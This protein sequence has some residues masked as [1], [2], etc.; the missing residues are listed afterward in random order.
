MFQIY[1]ILLELIRDGLSDRIN[2]ISP[3]TCFVMEKN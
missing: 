2:E 3:K 1:S